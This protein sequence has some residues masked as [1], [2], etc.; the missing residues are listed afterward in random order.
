M[1]KSILNTLSVLFFTSLS[2]H[3]VNLEDLSSEFAEDKATV[4]TPALKDAYAS[5]VNVYTVS[6]TVITGLM[7][8]F[9][10]NFL[11]TPQ[12]HPWEAAVGNAI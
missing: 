3:A 12:A 2:L 10:R 8:L 4:V 5:Y 1:K 9:A 7:V 11:K 6:A